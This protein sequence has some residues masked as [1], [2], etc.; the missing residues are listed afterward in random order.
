MKC[1]K[2]NSDI[3]FVA[4]NQ[5]LWFDGK[6]TR[7]GFGR[8]KDKFQSVTFVCN[9]IG[10]GYKIETW[11]KLS[12]KFKSKCKFKIKPNKKFKSN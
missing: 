9:S 4:S 11:C 2:C 8:F 3:G 12:I 10:C 5:A 1:P 7:V 6:N